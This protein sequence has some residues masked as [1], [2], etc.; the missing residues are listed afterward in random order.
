MRKEN[1]FHLLESLAK[2][3]N[4]KRLLKRGLALLSVVVLLFTMNVLKRMAVAIEHTPTCGYEYDHIHTDECYDDAGQLICGLH[5]HTDACYQETPE[6]VPEELELDLADIDEE[7]ETGDA[8]EAAGAEDELPNDEEAEDIEQEPVADEAAIAD[9]T[10]DMAGAEQALLSQILTA[11]NLPAARGDIQMVGLVDDT[12]AND[13]PV[14]I[15]LVDQEIT[16]TPLRDFDM[17]ELAV[18]TENDIFTVKLLNGTVAAPAVE[19]DVTDSAD[20]TGKAE[21]ADVTES[22]EADE[23]AVAQDVTDADEA[24]VEAPAE[25]VT[26][27]TEAV[28]ATEPTQDADVTENNVEPEAVEETPEAD[29]TEPEEAAD[30]AEDAGQA[31]VTEDAEAAEKAEN[32]DVTEPAEDAGKAESADVTEA[33]DAPEKAE[34][35]DVTESADAP[36]QAEDAGKTEETESA[37]AAE[38]T[39][40]ATDENGDAE[41]TEETESADAAENAEEATDENGEAEKTEETESADAAEDAEEATDENGEAEDAEQTEDAESTEDAE[42]TEDA[43]AIDE[44]LYP[45]QTFEQRAGGVRVNVTAEAGAFPADTE[46]RVKRVW[47]RDTLDGIADAV[48]EDFVEVKKVMAVDIAFYNAE[49]EEIE[50][51]R[52]IAVVMTV[53]EIEENQDAV[54]VHMDDEGNAEVV[55]QSE[56]PQTEDEKLALNVELPASEAPETAPEAG[57]EAADEAAPEAAPEAGDEAADETAP[58]AADEASEAAVEPGAE[59]AETEAAAASEDGLQIEE[60]AVQAEE[61]VDAET[62]AFEADAFSVYAVVVTETIDMKYIAQDGATYDISVGYGPEALIPVGAT[63]RVEELTG[64]DSADYLA[65]TEGLLAEGEH[66]ALARYFDIT[67]LDAEGV[68]VQPAAPVRVEVK[69]ADEPDAAVQAVHFA[70]EGEPEV[71]TASREDE[72][73]TFDAKSFSVYGIVYTVDFYYDVDGK[74][75]EFHINGGDVLPLRELLPILHVVEAD[76]AQGFVENIKDVTFTDESLVRVVRVT[77]GTTAGDIVDALDVEIEYSGRLSEEDIQ[78]MRAKAVAAPD[79]ALVSLK[80]FTSNETLTVTLING[81]VF[82]IRVEDAQTDL[83]VLVNDK[84][85]GYFRTDNN[86]NLF[87]MQN[88]SYK[89]I[90]DVDWYNGHIAGFKHIVGW[91]KSFG[92]EAN[93]GY[94]FAYWLRID[95]NG[96]TSIVVNSGYD[97]L[98]NADDTMNGVTLVAFFKPVGQNVVRFEKEG[99]GWI[100]TNNWE[101]PHTFT[102]QQ[103]TVH[104]WAYSNEAVQ[105]KAYA[106]YGY[107]V[108]GW[109]LNGNRVTTSDFIALADISEDR[110]YTAKIIQRQT[111]TINYKSTWYFTNIQF[112]GNTY[113]AAGAEGAKATEYVVDGTNAKGATAGMHGDIN[114]PSQCSYFIAWIDEEGRHVS[115]DTTFVPTGDQIR[116]ATYT[117]VFSSSPNYITIDCDYHCGKVAGT[118]GLYTGSLDLESAN[119]ADSIVFAKYNGNNQLLGNLWPIPNEGYEFDHWEWRPDSRWWDVTTINSSTIYATNT[120][121]N[122]EKGTLKAVFKPLITYDIGEINWVGINSPDVQHWHTASWCPA[123]T[124]NGLTAKDSSGNIFTEVTGVNSNYTIRNVSR[125]TRVTQTNN[126]YNLLTHYFTGWKADRE[127][128]VNGVKYDAGQ[129]IPASVIDGGATV[130]NVTEAIKFTAVWSS[131][132]PGKT[133]HNNVNTQ[134]GYRYNT[135][136]VG[137]FVRLFDNVFDIGNTKTYTDCLFSTRLTVTGSGSFAQGGTNGSRFDFF[138]NSKANVQDD[139]N[140]IDAALRSEATGGL[141]YSWSR[142]TSVQQYQGHDNRYDNVTIRLDAFPSDSFIFAQIRAW[143]LTASEDLKIEI[144]GTKIPQ[145]MIT[146]DFFDLKWYVLKDQ[147]NQWHIDGMLVPKYAKL[148]VK[149]TFAGDPE[150]MQAAKDGFSITVTE[151]NPRQGHNADTY[152]LNLNPKSDGNPYGYVE[153]YS[154]PSKN[155]YVWMLDHLIPL[156][157]YKV[158]ET[159]YTA[160]GFAV[161]KSY[162]ITNTKQDQDLSGYSDTATVDK[163]YSYADS[164]SW[165]SIQS[166]DFTNLY[167]KPYKLTLLKQDGT[168]LKGLA[169]VTFDYLLKEYTDSSFSTLADTNSTYSFRTSDDNGQ[170]TIDFPV[171]TD[172]T[173]YYSFELYERSHEGYNAISAIIGRA[174]VDKNGVVQLQNVS[175]TVEGDNVLVKVDDQN[176]A[177]V[178]VKNM[179]ERVNVKVVKRW[180]NDAQTPVVMQLLRNG[181]AMTGYSVTLNSENNWTHEWTNLPAYVNGKK[182]NYTVREEWIGEAGGV[183]SFHYSVRNDADGYE[184]FIV[185]QSQTETVDGDETNVEVYV[186][187]TPDEG[188]VKFSKVDEH[189]RALQGAEFTVYTNEGCTIIAKKSDNATNAVFTSDAKGVV[190]ITEMPIGPYYVKETVAPEGY[191][192]DETVYTLNVRAH[193]S[194]INYSDGKPVLEVINREYS[195]KVRLFKSGTDDHHKLSGAVFKLYASVCDVNGNYIRADLP[196]EG[197]GH[198]VSDENGLVVL[199]ELKHGKYFLV[200]ES[201]PA[202]YVRITEPIELTVNSM[203]KAKVTLLYNNTTHT[204]D[205]PATDENGEPIYE[206]YV[207]NNPGATLPSTGGTGTGAYTIAGAGLALVA[208]AL[209]LLKRRQA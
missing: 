64:A 129:L 13:A 35:A 162:Q 175:A 200:E 32:A 86:T 121:F 130:N 85:A 120:V 177:I 196:M 20:A 48:T 150:A 195:A 159:N 143:N 5:E 96:N 180:T 145:D 125:E 2:K 164:E 12:N 27:G 95:S 172:A 138:G 174:I 149:K 16:V 158:Q 80:P 88:G 188:Q 37:D 78:A 10:Y 179:P 124:V 67:I 21:D 9:Y 84:N 208:V 189:H 128:Y 22:A 76:E 209:L 31:D 36:E 73:V 191:T 46:M 90:Q 161:T 87:L 42:E 112:D 79:W 173:H 144:N 205:T 156:T 98:K 29:V 49:G 24:A 182:C 113:Y 168:T 193:N 6:T 157:Q 8:T 99:N 68:E 47:D 50:P 63:L 34:S 103:G 54:V 15:A 25:D 197:C 102:D 147:E 69:L 53:D 137:F 109:Y 89:Y 100:S 110:V 155:Q 17:V 92:V 203:T 23:E 28:E 56:A 65:R 70:Q 192:L 146:E 33:A 148:V 1:G 91:Y 62:V 97:A 207:H 114:N 181:A 40:E 39:E 184:E 108:D 169:N 52:P 127:V 77:E 126:G 75:Y 45:A 154:N 153:A 131:T 59:A 160:S 163:C 134:V 170:L 139:I 202:G 140:N 171:K 106:N 81:E 132:F 19:A 152:A 206:L 11:T 136:S 199:K 165:Q 194:T 118:S 151:Q 176:P 141:N 135:N 58:E 72:A 7:A 74:T 167:T 187:N 4:R 116:N 198:L 93:P 115:N 66:I 101:T 133:E 44:A 30:A 38:N 111:F 186:E 83:Q 104:G 166:V 18:V 201:A 123:V 117:A 122:G 119:K 41:K 3:N 61:P 183:N 43:E 204:D 51:L 26:E 14:A 185:T 190:E 105:A 142:F 94:E 178:Y 55:E 82:V 107:K 57:D 71:I 60:E